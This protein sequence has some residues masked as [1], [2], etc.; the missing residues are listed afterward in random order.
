MWQ[1]VNCVFTAGYALYLSGTM[2]RVT[3][4]TS[5]GER[6]SEFSMVFYNNFLSLGP[7]LVLILLFGESKTLPQQAA[8][9]NPE[10]L[11]V[12]A[13][14]GVLGFGISFTSLWWVQRQGKAHWACSL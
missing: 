10:F 12:A 11:T 14:S 1:L 9:A 8:L 5:T 7:V 13:A 3:P 4:H 2:G 6:L